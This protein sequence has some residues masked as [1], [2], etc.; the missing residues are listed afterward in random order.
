LLNAYGELK[1]DDVRFAFGRVFDLFG[2]IAPNTVNMG[3]QRGAGN[4][5]FYRGAIH[6]DRYLTWSDVHKWTLSARIAQQTIND[7]LVVP[8]IRGKDNGWPNIEMRVG[9]ELGQLQD[10]VRP[11]EIGVSGLIEA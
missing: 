7:Y 8:Q 2:P 5:G 6:L 9:V 3:Q 11:L 4:V 1:N 10:G